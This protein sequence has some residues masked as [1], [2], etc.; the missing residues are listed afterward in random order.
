[1]DLSLIANLKDIPA[2]S[3]FLGAQEQD[4]WLNKNSPLFAAQQ[5][6]NKLMANNKTRIPMVIEYLQEAGNRISVPMYINPQRLNM[7]NQKIKSKAVTRGG[8]FYHHWGDDHW[9]M[10]LSGTVGDAGMEGIKKLETIYHLSGVLL[11]YGLNS[12]GPVYV[13][14]TTSFLDML[15]KG[16][17]SGAVGALMN[18][19]VKNLASSFMNQAKAGVVS[20]ITGK[21]STAL[22]STATFQKVNA[23]VG[24]GISKLTG[25]PAAAGLKGVNSALA[26][27]T[28]FNT[29]TSFLGQVGGALLGNI[30]GNKLGLN[31]P[32]DTQTVDYATASQGWADI[33]D[34]LEDPWRPRQIWIYFEDRVF[35]GHFDSFSYQ[36]VAETPLIN[37]DMRFTVTRQVVVTS[38]NP[39]KPE[40]VPAQAVT[41]SAAYTAAAAAKAYSGNI[42]KTAATKLAEFST[43]TAKA[44][45]DAKLE[46]L[47]AK[48]TYKSESLIAESN[49]LTITDQRSTQLQD[50]MKQIRKA[51]GIAD[52]DETY[53]VRDITD[54]QRLDYYTLSKA[55]NPDGINS[56]AAKAVDAEL[57]RIRALVIKQK[58]DKKFTDIIKQAD[59]DW[60]QKI[61]AAIGTQDKYQAWELE[62]KP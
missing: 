9:Q 22:R 2:V 16:D 1:M 31:S 28:K 6:H 34:E 56:D 48:E 47:K 7:S 11:Q 15:G 38:Y 42:P 21:G 51:T 32:A 44:I 17:F 41:T 61:H 8:I 13:D 25:Q 27:A 24:A 39:Q 37:Y 45:R 59:W 5:V 52:S 12:A 50:W 23:M 54:Q 18:G 14:G 46:I 49:G 26:S 43:K 10:Q 4:E 33:N 3:K 55:S 57:S 35:I 36:R 40:F 29:G 58:N 62:L 30:I 19:G 53:G 20:A 60:I